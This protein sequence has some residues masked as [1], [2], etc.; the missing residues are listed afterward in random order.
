M[1]PL[2]AASQSRTAVSVPAGNVIVSSFRWVRLRRIRP[3]VVLLAV[4]HAAEAAPFW[5]NYA[6]LSTVRPYCRSEKQETRYE[7]PAQACVRADG[8]AAVVV[9]DGR[10]A[11]G[12]AIPPAGR[13][14][15]TGASDDPRTRDA[16]ARHGRPLLRHRPGGSW[17]VGRR[18][19]RAD[20]VPRRHAAHQVQRPQDRVA[21]SDPVPER[22]LSEERVSHPHRPPASHGATALRHAGGGAD[23]PAGA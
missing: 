12:G 6:N 7:N 3:T 1:A 18:P 23:R 21:A 14:C 16:A 4:P 19:H 2:W 15:G 13:C 5:Y 11:G 20:I 22:E 10:R 9:H 8:R 17:T